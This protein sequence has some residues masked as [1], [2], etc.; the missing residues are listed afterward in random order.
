LLVALLLV[1]FAVSEAARRSPHSLPEHAMPCVGW[2]P[3][4]NVAIEIGDETTRAACLSVP[5]NALLAQQGTRWA[6]LNL[7]RL[8]NETDCV[9][10]LASSRIRLEQWHPAK[11]PRPSSANPA[12]GSDFPDYLR[13]PPGSDASGTEMFVPR[14]A[15]SG[16]RTISCVIG[17]H[18]CWATARDELLLVKWSTQRQRM[19]T[20]LAQDWDCLRGI[21][22]AARID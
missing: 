22:K 5:K 1:A 19:S 2:W 8:D 11:T 12:W 21:V 16:L 13:F 10:R 17:A 7:M 3:L 4:G 9:S 18:T 20:G 15:S 6:E 14:N